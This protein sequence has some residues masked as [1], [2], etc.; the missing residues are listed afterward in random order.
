MSNSSSAPERVMS[1]SSSAPERVMSNS[2]IKFKF[3]REVEVRSRSEE[4][5]ERGKERE[6]GGSNAPDLPPPPS[7]PSPQVG[8]VKA[9]KTPPKTRDPLLDNPAVVAYRELARL[10]PNAEQRAAIAAAVT[11]EERWRRVVRE[12]L[13]HGW[14]PGNV[15]GM[16]ERYA[17]NGPGPPRDHASGAHLPP[18]LAALALVEA[19][20][21]RAA[22][23]NYGN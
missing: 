10:T 2:A 8:A 14:K 4:I 22:G 18:A 17:G 11:D 6:S 23:G 20:D 15:A 16:L 7:T 5:R 21:Q 3:K 9:T 12:W 19:E 1:N 13:T